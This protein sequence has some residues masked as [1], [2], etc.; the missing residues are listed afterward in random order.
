M[1]STI[2]KSIGQPASTPERKSTRES[3]RALLRTTQFS[4]KVGICVGCGVTAE[5]QEATMLFL[6]TGETMQVALPLCP[7]CASRG[8]GR[9]LPITEPS[10]LQ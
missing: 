7:E 3:L 9:T 1:K 10:F 2:E 8:S 5:F 4:A 6:E